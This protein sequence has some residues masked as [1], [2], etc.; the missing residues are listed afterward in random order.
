MR[1]LKKVGT[2]EMKCGEQVVIKKNSSKNILHFGDLATGLDFKKMS[3]SSPKSEKLHPD[4]IK[5]IMFL[6][7]KF[8]RLCLYH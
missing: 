2:E 6:T 1:N 7:V 3:R 8:R 4:I 5:Q